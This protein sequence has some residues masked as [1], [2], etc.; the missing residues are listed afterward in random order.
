MLV[1]WTDAL[2]Y[3]L[4][5]ACIALAWMLSRQRH[6]RR[7]LRALTANPVAMA[8]LTLLLCFVLIGLADSI[9]FRD[10]DS[11]G[12]DAISL[13]DVAIRMSPNT[14]LNRPTAVASPKRN[15]SRPWR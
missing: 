11:R 2:I 8:S 12:N 15:S 1:L 10:D 4:V 6:L 3:A 7:P 5:L 9:H 14:P 13:L